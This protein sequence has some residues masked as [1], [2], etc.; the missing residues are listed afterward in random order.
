MSQ[1]K[2]QFL[3]DFTRKLWGNTEIRI[4]GDISQKYL[5]IWVLLLLSKGRFSVSMEGFHLIFPLLIRLG[6]LT[7]NW[8]FHMKERF[9]VI[10]FY[11]TFFYLNFN[12]HFLY[13]SFLIYFLYL[14]FLIN[15]LYLNLLTNPTNFLSSYIL[16]EFKFYFIFKI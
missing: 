2:F 6:L 10:F 16:F 12:V 14:S 13:L 11:L 1:D 5:I 7:G 4:L 9:V 15:F 8:K 3:T